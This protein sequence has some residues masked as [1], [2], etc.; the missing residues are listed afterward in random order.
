MRDQENM[1]KET[2]WKL[3]RE[4]HLCRI[5][6]RQQLILMMGTFVLNQFLSLHRCI[7]FLFI[8]T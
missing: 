2:R 3:Q 5:S 1:S 4:G 8:I 6:S 7:Y